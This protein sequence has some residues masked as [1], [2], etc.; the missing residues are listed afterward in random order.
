MISKL[1]IGSIALATCSCMS[2]K[3]LTTDVQTGE[4]LSR[5]KYSNYGKATFSF[6]YGLRDDPSLTVTHNDWDIEFGN[7]GDFFS[8]TMV[9]DDRSRI[10]DLGASTWTDLK[11]SSDSIPHPYPAPAREPSV[12]VIEGHIYVIRTVDRDSD[13]TTLLRVESLI[14]GDRVTFTWKPL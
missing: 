3:A 11:I 9:T 2:T 10:A 7:G 6:E 14:P 8:V 13:L 5:Q 4:L 1:F 12:A